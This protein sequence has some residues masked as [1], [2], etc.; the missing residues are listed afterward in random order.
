M[1]VKT[2]FHI[3]VLGKGNLQRTENYKVLLIDV[4]N[5]TKEDENKSNKERHFGCRCKKC[6]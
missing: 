2:I 6:N 4:R 3:L 1:A 5:V